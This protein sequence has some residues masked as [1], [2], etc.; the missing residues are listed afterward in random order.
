MTYVYGIFIYIVNKF[1]FNL[2]FIVLGQKY[3]MLELKSILSNVLR[4]FELFPA[5][6][7]KPYVIAEGVMKSGNGILV[8][9]ENR[10]Y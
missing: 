9:F 8:R 1:F 7:F 2:K 3:A 6:D 5:K 10:R 4:K